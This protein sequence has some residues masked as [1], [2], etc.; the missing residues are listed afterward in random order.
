MDPAMVIL[1][2]I[3]TQMNLHST[4][5]VVYAVGFLLS[6]AMGVCEWPIS[7]PWQPP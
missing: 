2:T 3:I 5:N 4:L 1:I 7:D 6:Q